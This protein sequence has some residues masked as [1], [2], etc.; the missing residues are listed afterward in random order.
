MNPKVSYRDVIRPIW[1]SVRIYDGADVFLR[2][3]SGL[4]FIQRVLFATHWAQSEVM[5]GGLG[6]FFSNS[7]GVLAPEAVEGFVALRMPLCASA[8]SDAM[9][10]F[11]APYPRDRHMRRV[12]MEK[13]ER[14]NPQL[15]LFNAQEDAIA[16]AL[17]DEGGG[18]WSVAD[19]FAG[20]LVGAVG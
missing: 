13:F 19:R 8:V 1:D 3:F 4:S 12:L 15:V 20:S 14:D 11:G 10:F 2:G 6:Q 9:L 18:Y 7:T 16:V 5:N 17:E